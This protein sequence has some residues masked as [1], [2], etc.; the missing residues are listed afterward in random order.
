MNSNNCYL[1]G[2]KVV[3]DDLKQVLKFFAS[4]QFAA[5]HIKKQIESGVTF[6]RF[7]SKCGCKSLELVFPQ[8]KLSLLGNHV[9][10]N[11]TIDMFDDKN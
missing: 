10:C 7:V 5:M 2:K 6:Q 3:C 4:K 11:K 9:K 1:I 8:N